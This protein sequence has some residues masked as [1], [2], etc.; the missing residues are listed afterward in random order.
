[1][2]GNR[3]YSAQQCCPTLV[4]PN[5]AKRSYRHYKRR[6][7][8]TTYSIFYTSNTAIAC[9]IVNPLRAGDLSRRCLA[10]LSTRY[11]SIRLARR[12]H[13]AAPAPAPAQAPAATAKYIT[14][15]RTD[16]ADRWRI[17]PSRRRSIA[18]CSFERGTRHTRYITSATYNLLLLYLVVNY[19]TTAVTPT[20]N[21]YSKQYHP[22]LVMGCGRL[23]PS[24]AAPLDMK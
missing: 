17:I 18:I 14:D 21:Y 8:G 1:M 12:R 9:M 7:T 24:S 6:A 5:C 15:S 20:N 4:N 19:C 11:C 22:R 3:Y 13:T 10:V 2:T 23:F 16:D